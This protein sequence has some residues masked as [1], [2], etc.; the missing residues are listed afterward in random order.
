MSKTTSDIFNLLYQRFSV[1]PTSVSLDSNVTSEE[2]LSIPMVKILADRLVTHYSWRSDQQPLWKYLDSLNGTNDRLYES[3]TQSKL[4]EADVWEEIRLVGK[5]SVM[6]IIS[7]STGGVISAEVSCDGKLFC[8]EINAEEDA[9]Y[10]FGTASTYQ[11]AAYYYN[12]INMANPYSLVGTTSLCFRYEE[13][14][15]VRFKSTVV[16]SFRYRDH[17]GIT[18]A[19]DHS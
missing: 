13:E 10:F 6:N 8:T 7:P 9:R 12:K 15:T 2:P 17:F 11:D 19:R 16:D 1:D 18:Y 4:L 14:I 3:A 5:G